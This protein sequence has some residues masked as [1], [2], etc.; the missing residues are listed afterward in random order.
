M[1]LF[2]NIAMLSD[3]ITMLA[4][5][6]LSSCV[7]LS[8]ARSVPKYEGPRKQRSVIESSFVQPKFSAKFQWITAN[9]VAKYRWV[10]LK[11]VIFDQ[12]LT[13]SETEHDRGH[14]FTVQCRSGL[15]V[16]CLTAV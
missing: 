8:V 1:M 2:Y 13:I 14:R 16:T 6:M 3:V 5:Y 4:R 11:S 12:Y 15:A 10:R 9:G 7:R